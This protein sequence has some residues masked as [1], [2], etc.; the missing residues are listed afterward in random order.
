MRREEISEALSG[1][2]SRYVLEAETYSWKR[3]RAARLWRG[4]TAVAA[5][6]CLAVLAQA[7]LPRQAGGIFTVKAYALDL[8]ENGTVVLREEDLLEKSDY[9][10]GYCDGENY[11]INLG[12]PITC[13]DIMAT[14]GGSE[15]LEIILSC[16]LEDGDEILIPEPYYPNYATFVGV[17][18]ASI[19]AIPTSPEAG[20]RYATREQ[21]EPL[22]NEHTRAI[23]VTNPGN[24]TG[25]VLN[26]QEMRLLADIAKEHE[27][28][29][30]SDEVYREIVY[31]GEK[32]SSM[33]EF[34]D[35]AENVAVVDSVSKRFSS[36]GAR[37]GALISRNKELMAQAMKICQGRLCAAT[38]DQ[39][40]AAA[41]YRELPASYYT[42][43]REEYQRRRD[44]VV[45]SLAKIPGVQFSHP[46]GA[47]YV[48][49]TLPVDDAEKLQYFLLEEFEDHG[50]TV[51]YTPAESFYVTPGKGRNEIRIAYVTNPAELSR[52]I[53]LLGL[54]IAAY[55]SRRK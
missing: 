1:I 53:E 5:L 35:A 50:E 27:L 23:L 54:G 39:V 10:G 42:A 29:L 24:P 7:L 16:I 9:W 26:R 52:S 14:H 46:D 3:R 20:Y 13:D 21:I 51:M 6:L 19:R 28:F 33:L 31:T 37:V 44:T 17:T 25:V 49:A 8:D 22:I 55:N 15:A 41:M 36:C 34:T 40:G 38:L 48:M 30:I 12:F 4:G 47:F 18:G 2:D 32:L 43:V 11:Y 45:E